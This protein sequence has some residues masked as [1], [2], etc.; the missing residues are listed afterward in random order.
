MKLSRIVT[1][2]AATA[3]TLTLTAAC[4]GGSG[5]AEESGTGTLTVWMMTGGPGED[6]IIEDVNSEFAKKY[7]DMD[8]KVEIQQWDNIATKITTALA[9]GKG[10]D[11]VEM[12]NT[13]TALQT[14]SGALL[15][16]TDEKKSF[17]DSD[18]WL[19][20]LA[21]PS[22]YEDRLYAAPLYGG[23]KVV[24]YNK[25][26]FAEASIK[27]APATLDE[28][29]SDCAN[30][31]K[32]YEGTANYSGFY[33]PGQYWFAGA[34]FVFGKGGEL[35]V[36]KDG[37]WS[38]TLSEPKAQAGLKAW[39]E[40]QN[41]CST[42]SSRGVNTNSPDQ[43]QLFADG[44]TAM[45]E[46]KAW[47]P[48]AVVEKNPKLKDKIGY[49]VM[50]GYTADKPLPTIVAGSTI[51]ISTATQQPE[52]AKAW[53]KIVTGKDFQGKMAQKLNLLPVSA[54]FLPTEG[55]TEALSVGSKAAEIN[56]AMP[57]SPGQA[58][59]DGERYNEQFFSAVVSGKDVKAQAKEYDAHV[60]EAYSANG[61]TS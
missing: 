35:A 9:S 41:T 7:P 30:L 27:A 10:P 38:G 3:L 45:L 19:A 13:Q 55:V 31:Q 2:G 44:R 29:M 25:D 34:P 49:F 60:T 42:P 22:T 59:L 47:E 8:V 6:P 50:P 61:A 39:K 11:I 40:F 46:V 16:I 5:S 57:V 48:A 53:L 24:M 52:A 56:H 58:T 23:T 37:K 14:Y 51:G 4:S 17:E 20:G 33:M 1:A 28:L 43:D 36:E 12:G 15:D 26:M 54:S 32:A 18:K 21:A